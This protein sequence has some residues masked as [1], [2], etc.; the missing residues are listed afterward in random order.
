MSEEPFDPVKQPLPTYVNRITV[1]MIDAK[2]DGLGNPPEKKA[3]FEIIIHDQFEKVYEDACRRGNLARHL[4]D[5]DKAWLMD[6][7]ARLRAKAE[8]NLLYVPPE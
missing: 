3:T 1:T 7:M 8:S 2:S 4:S 5:A 6:F